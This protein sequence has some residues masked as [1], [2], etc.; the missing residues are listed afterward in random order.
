[1][2]DNTITIDN[3]SSFIR[4]VGDNPTAWKYI[5]SQCNQQLLESP[6]IFH[7]LIKNPHINTILK[8]MPSSICNRRNFV[9]HAITRNVA[10]IL[11]IGKK[12]KY[13]KRLM[14][15][16]VSNINL[17]SLYIDDS[18][19]GF[20]C[21]FKTDSN[22][23]LKIIVTL[24]EFFKYIHKKF[25]NKYW[26]SKALEINFQ[27]FEF[28]PDKFK[29]QFPIYRV[30]LENYIGVIG[31]DD[32]VVGEDADK[33][34]YLFSSS[35]EDIK[36]D[37]KYVLRAITNWPRSFKH[38]SPNLRNDLELCKYAVS[39]YNDNIMYCSKSAQK[40]LNY[41]LMADLFDK[42]ISLA[43]MRLIIGR[44][45]FACDILILIFDSLPKI[46]INILYKSYEEL[47]YKKSINTES[48]SYITA[49]RKTGVSMCAGIYYNNLFRHG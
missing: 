5:I 18:F 43:H 9:V 19:K 27:V 39:L 40:E 42:E 24:P 30:K 10:N 15:F 1:M 33:P 47:I 46:N 14:M 13:D 20:P 17:S 41:K 35:D 28:I 45:P 31:E 23:W 3:K 36:K 2:I 32:D 8:Y 48:N 11:Y 16:I 49:L 21:Y 25:N 34:V 26:I 29:H 6:D 7:I 12:I 44:L 37:K 22:Y 4:L 38:A